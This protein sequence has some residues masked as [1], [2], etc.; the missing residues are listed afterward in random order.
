[1]RVS[2]REK[3]RSVAVLLC[4]GASARLYWVLFH[5]AAKTTS[6]EPTSAGE[7]FPWVKLLNRDSLDS[8]QRHTNNFTCAYQFIACVAGLFAL[9]AIVIRIAKTIESRRFALLLGFTA[10]LFMA[11]LLCSPVMLSSDTYA[12][13]YYGR[14]LAFHGL[15]AHAVAPKSTLSDPFLMGGYYD[16]MPSVYGP[17]WTLISAG[18][19]RIAGSHIGL[20]LL[21]FRSLEAAATLGSG[22]LVYS[23]LRRLSPQK[24][25]WGTAL[26]LWNPLVVMESALGGHN[27]AC[28]M[29][30]A[31]LAVWLHLR[32][33]KAACVVALTVSA[34]VK[35]VTAPLVPLYILLILRRSGS[36]KKDA[37]FVGRAAGG[38]AAAIVIA[39][40][41]ARMNPNGLTAHTAGSAEFYENNYHQLVFK[42]LRH[43]F[44]EAADTLNTPM[45]FTPWWAATSGHAI[46]H[47]GTGNKTPDLR[48][49]KDDQ[50][51]LVISD[52]DSDDWLR[53]YDPADHIEGYV[54]WPH[55]SVI[56]EPDDAEKDPT[57]RRL[58]AWPQ[59]WPTVVKA[60]RL[61]RV[62]TWSLFVAFGL[63]A[64]WKT[65]DFERFLHWSTL[66]FLAAQLLVFTWIWPWYA[67]WPLAFSALVPGRAAGRLAVLMSAGMICLYPLI[68]FATSHWDWIYE[69][70]S[71]P[72]IVLPVAVFALM[73][74][75]RLFTRAGRRTTEVGL[76][77]SRDAKYTKEEGLMEPSI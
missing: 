32:G 35:V 58:A 70:R 50:A 26:F 18:I 68:S 38:A 21:L 13:S 76:S 44:G 24:A 31:L 9:Y 22:G 52:E 15:D 3:L 37:V 10:A 41:G 4:A 36:W 30:F 20:T 60:N 54:S 2:N 69:D 11:V 25:V 74:A 72:T 27:D 61:I 57:I 77:S 67:I 40:L 49:L 29:W 63:M 75:W 14:L 16:F 1:M 64:A 66:F 5:L 47:A 7:V 53:V 48:R 12:Y 17:L 28:M 55:V 56:D 8:I 51:L 23:I 62:F 45:D 34:L 73:E 33:N 19:T 39:V 65:T 59:E 71:I 43:L 46:L 42:G 6:A